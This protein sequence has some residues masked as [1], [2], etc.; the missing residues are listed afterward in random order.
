MAADPRRPDVLI[1]GAGTAG[2]AA[3]L[4]CARRGLSVLCLDRRPLDEAG[5]RWV[6]GV[7]RWV[8]GAVGLAPPLPPEERSRGVP[9]RMVAGW[10]GP[11]VVLA[12][13]DLLEVDMR[14]LV[15]RLQAEAQAAGATLLGETPVESWDGE[16]ARTPAGDLIPKVIV[17]ASGLGGTIWPLA[18]PRETLCAA[19]AEERALLDP[20]AAKHFFESRGAAL[21]DTLSFTGV[22][23]GYSIVNVRAADGHVTLLTGSIPAQG[24]KPG[25][26]LLNEFVASQPWIGERL[27]GGARAVPLDLP[28]AVVGEANRARLGDAA[29]QVFSSHGSGIAQGLLA[30]HLLAE[31]LASGGGVEAYNLRFQRGSAGALAAQVIFRRFS[32]SLTP[33][34]TKT[35]FAAA[36][37]RPAVAKLVLTQ[38]PPWQAPF[39]L[40][41][42][43][44]GLARAPG[45]AARLVPALAR[46]G[47][48]EAL[49]RVYPS[50]PGKVA[51]WEERRRKVVG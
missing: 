46:M 12:E 11:Q 24:H 37:V 28:A 26:V 31:C 5:A 13:H 33:E 27:Y 35:L 43:M 21:G 4:F 45:L 51:G 32:M 2:A 20:Q 8:F 34:E 6:N 17:D 14:A 15:R 7:P 1:V 18:A 41:A 19:A 38:R 36:V 48:V 50:D 25:V 47:A 16:T 10:D 44:P 30:A 22:A 49:H 39:A 42:G 40:L 3:A 23:G 9:F 29:G